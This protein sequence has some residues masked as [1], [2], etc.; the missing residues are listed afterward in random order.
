MELE[1]QLHYQKLLI[2]FLNKNLMYELQL[3][4]ILEVAQLSSY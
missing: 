4:I 2:Y 1:N 3:E